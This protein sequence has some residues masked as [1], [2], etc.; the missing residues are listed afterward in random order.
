[1]GNKSKGAGQAF[2][3]DAP[4]GQEG[5]NSTQKACL[6]SPTML[7]KK[8][9]VTVRRDYLPASRVELTLTA[10]KSFAGK[11]T[12]TC[13]SDCVALYKD[14]S[15]IDARAGLVMESGVVLE[16]EGLKAS[17][18]DGV[19]FSWKLQAGAEPVAADTSRDKLTV[20]DATVDVYKKDGTTVL[21]VAEKAGDGRTVHKQNAGNAFSRARLVVKCVP[22]EWVGALTLSPISDRLKLFNQ[23]TGGVAEKLKKSISV[24]PGKGPFEY[25]VEGAAESSAKS[26]TGFTLKIEGAL[27]DSDLA[28]MTVV[29]TALDVYTCPASGSPAKVEGV[30]KTDPGRLLLMQTAKFERPR[31]KLA[32]MK[33]PKDAPCKLA[34]KAVSG[35]E[36]IFL[37]PAE[38]EKHRD[39]E[40]AVG[41]AKGIGVNDI[42]DEATG[43][44]FWIDG[45]AL[46]SSPQETVL[47]LD[48]EGVDEECDKVA[49]TVVDLRAGNGHDPAPYLVP[50]K[51]PLTESLKSHIRVVKL[52]HKLGGV[53][54]AWSTP[55]NRL[56]VSDETKQTVTLTGSKNPSDSARSDALELVLTPTGKTAFEKLT[57]KVGVVKVD[58]APHPDHGGGYD[59]FEPMT[60]VYANGNPTNNA[61]LVDPKH[62]ILSIEKG[63]VGKVQ[64]TFKGADAVDIFFTSDEPAKA[65]PKVEKP[66]GSPF[67]LELE[68]KAVDSKAETVIKA[69]LERKDG[70]I[71]AQLG[72]VVLAKTSVEAEFFAVQD[73]RYGSSQL[74]GV[75]KTITKVKLNDHLKKAYSSAI[76]ELK[77][78]SAALKNVPYAT[79]TSG[80]IV[81]LVPGSVSTDESKIKTE[82]AFDM[83]KQNIVCAKGLEWIFPITQDV[84]I[85]KTGPTVI[86]ATPTKYFA[87]G[88]WHYLKGDGE[89]QVAVV[90][91]QVV[92]AQEVKVEVHPSTP[93]ANDLPFTVAKKAHLVMGLNGLSGNPV[94]VLDQAGDEALANVI[95]HEVGHVKFGFADLCEKT[96][97]MYY[98]AVGGG[99]WGLRHRKVTQSYDPWGEEQQWFTIPGR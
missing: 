84:L 49:L 7:L 76:S 28:K 60:F 81:S 40:S 32:V 62:D 22:S 82:C 11:G 18:L 54:Y 13:A 10:D 3:K 68:G 55:G 33:K 47:Q 90:V 75:G 87:V 17:A 19:E 78:T 92:S 86:K 70:H 45:K 53:T 23:K 15:K 99:N 79:A 59:K 16:I 46:S 38:H 2:Q 85:K 83:N 20:V 98:T 4:K 94:W 50:V 42:V 1:V 72:A 61:K 35:G 57:H 27:G 80:G 71:A 95:G 14:G 25:W 34:L 9:V 91:K 58:F 93:I 48:A 43:M 30:A 89:G 88:A 31:T 65:K 67:A 36:R 26:D 74:V 21:T 39:G 63:K 52:E 37:F 24:G 44:V 51:T 69:R 73:S 12:F 8:H 6:V 41:L 77:I 29:A 96:N 5:T 56:K 64:V 97:L 66:T